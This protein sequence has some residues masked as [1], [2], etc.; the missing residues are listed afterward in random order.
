MVG[1]VIEHLGLDDGRLVSRLPIPTGQ[2]G[3]SARDVTVPQPVLRGLKGRDS[4]GHGLFSG[5]SHEALAHRLAHGHPPSRRSGHQQFSRGHIVG[6]IQGHAR[7]RIV[8]ALLAPHPGWHP[9]RPTSGLEKVCDG[10]PPEQEQRRGVR[11]GQI[12]G[13]YIAGI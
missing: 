8:T 10:C 7:Q 1:G 11:Q 6:S 5:Q 9:R 12:D 13:L 3:L 2:R 4:G